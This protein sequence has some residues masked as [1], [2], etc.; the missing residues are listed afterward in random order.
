MLYASAGP[1]PPITNIIIALVLLIG[2][3]VIDIWGANSLRQR[4][5][6]AQESHAYRD[7]SGLPGIGPAR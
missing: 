7:R 6:V 3:A 2:V 1:N 4:R 5:A